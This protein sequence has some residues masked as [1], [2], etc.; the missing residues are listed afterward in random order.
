MKTI[1]T[2]LAA[3]AL[4]APA[5]AQDH[6]GHVVGRIMDATCFARGEKPDADH[7]AC[8][9]KCI[10]GGAPIL[11]VE[12]K[13]GQVFVALSAPGKSVKNMLLPYVGRRT[14]VMGKIVREGGVLYRDAADNRTPLVPYLKAAIF[15]VAGDWNAT[16][17]HVVIALALGGAAIGVWQ[18]CRRLGDERTGLA[19]ALLFILYSF[20]LIGV[21]ESQAAHTEWFQIFFSV[22]A[23]LVFAG[24]VTRPSLAR[25]LG[26][27][28]LFGA[29]ALCKQPGL[30]D[31]GVT[32]VI[33]GLLAWSAR[34]AERRGFVALVLGELAGLAAVFAATFAYFAANGA[35]DDFV[36][37]A[38]TYNTKFYVAEVPLLEHDTVLVQQAAARIRLVRFPQ[39]DVFSVLRSK[40]KWGER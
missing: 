20:T 18:L 12:E 32:L 33:A 6:G 38:W 17:V 40:L 11:V 36:Q 24:G 2:A 10:R 14:E 22:P 28:A 31:L 16:A 30:L 21:H 5:L 15:A 23:F 37:Y 39:R 29:A 34:G 4:A 8:A 25:G 13:T 3:A 35:L 9:E 1:W 7:A 27:G 26:I 19:A